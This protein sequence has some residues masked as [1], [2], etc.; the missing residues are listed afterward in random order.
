MKSKGIYR[1]ISVC[2]KLISWLQLILSRLSLQ[3]KR[4]CCYFQDLSSPWITQKYIL[5]LF[6]FFTSK[7]KSILCYDSFQ[8]SNFQYPEKTVTVLTTHH[9][10]FFSNISDTSTTNKESVH[11]VRTMESKCKGNNNDSR[12][13]LP[14]CGWAVWSDPTWIMN[15]AW[16]TSDFLSWTAL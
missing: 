7:T 13:R 5:I 12:R 10:V 14:N 9:K 8:P 1:I 16:R 6:L 3:H 15:C 11:S 2:H 4:L